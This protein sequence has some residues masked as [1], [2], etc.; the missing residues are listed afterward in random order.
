MPFRSSS[1]T[2]SAVVLR[3]APLLNLSR[4]VLRPLLAALHV[5]LSAGVLTAG[6]LVGDA[7]AQERGVTAAV[8]PRYYDVP[9]G[10]LANA[11]SR[12]AEL[13]GVLLTASGDLTWGKLSAGLSGRYDV[14]QGFAALLSGSGLEAFLLADGSYGLRLVPSSVKRGETVLSPVSVTAGAL[15]DATT[16]G[17]G[18]YTT[19]GV[20]IGKGV[21][22][23]KETPQSVTVMTRQLLDD[24]NLNTIDQ[25]MEKVPGVTVTDSPMGGKYFYARGFLMSGQYQYDGVPLDIG[26][27]YPQADSFSGEMGYYDRVEFLHG[28]ASMMKGVGTPA[29][30]V[31]FVRKRGQDQKA[32]D[33]SLAA[34]SWNSYRMQLD[35]GGPLNE[36]GTLRG[37]AVV[38]QSDRH[39]FYD[40][41]QRQDQTIYAALD[42]DVSS[43]TILG[44]GF[45]YENL[46]ATPCWHGLPRYQNGADLKLNRS[47]CLNPNWSRW[48][49][50]R[51]S[52]FVDLDHRLKDD[53]KLKVAAA[54]SRNTQA[55]KYA[56]AQDAVNVGSAATSIGVF[57][58][59]FDYEHRD[60]GID[61]YVDGKFRAFGQEHQLTI[62]AT[63]SRGTR[64]DRWALAVLPQTQ[65]VFAPN[66]D[67]PEPDS[68]WIVANAYRGGSHPDQTT[69]SQRGVYANARFK[70]ADPSTL[71]VGSRLS[72]YDYD[73]SDQAWGELSQ[74]TMKQQKKL[75]PFGAFIQKLTSNVSAYASYAE[76]FQPQYERS[77]GGSTLPSKTGTS[78]EL[79]VKGEWGN[80]RLNGAANFFRTDQLHAAV[81]VDSALCQAS[82]YCYADSGKVRTE[83]FEAELSGSPLNRLQVAAGYT[84]ARSKVLSPLDSAQMSDGQVYNSHMP[85]HMLRVWS[86]YQLAGELSRWSVGGGVT[87]QSDIYRTSNQ[88]RASQSGYAVWSGR[89]QYRLDES[90]NLAL[91]LNNLF[92]KRYYYTLG[93]T[94]YGNH[95]GEPR[96]VMLTL[97]G[98]F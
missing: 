71:I 23:L 40:V 89:V 61:A 45:A 7:R 85:I 6:V 39:Y 10:P 2:D 32:V 97:R 96:N 70:L 57:G 92:D 81:S 18:S 12:F 13:A 67:L 38:A 75:T 3:Y 95:Y 35:A 46:D 64:N 74:L 82:A 30:A 22:S 86:N 94:T 29:G 88:I 36:A 28:A 79:G 77:V 19:G 60:Y 93:T 54:Y 33:I 42:M 8:Q 44:L 16:E 50:E 20:T 51:T 68:A 80:G 11:L 26:S 76:I 9:A 66:H 58:G 59:T 98:S 84:F 90:W 62:G 65:N 73:H 5:M 34:G 48:R 63:A 47:T 31:N 83:G 1:C 69:I 56:F 21:R 41:A 14:D 55:I 49:S 15:R 87:A 17:T 91:N 52:L 27:G 37:R 43:D 72:W 53:W 4:P 24:Q 25:V 78:Y